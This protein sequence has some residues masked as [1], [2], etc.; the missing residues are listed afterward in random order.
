M[1]FFLKCEQVGLNSK[2]LI[3]MYSQYSCSFAEMK[4]VMYQVEKMSSTE[5]VVPLFQTY[6]F[7]LIKMDHLYK[8]QP[9]IYKTILSSSF[10]YFCTLFEHSLPIFTTFLQFGEFTK[11][12]IILLYFLHIF[13]EEKA[14]YKVG[15]AYSQNKEI[16][17]FPILL[18]KLFDFSIKNKEENY[19]INF[20]TQYLFHVTKYLINNED[21]LINVV[22][23]LVDSL[24]HEKHP[25]SLHT[26]FYFPYGI[27][28]YFETDPTNEIEIEEIVNKHFIDNNN[29]N[30]LGDYDNQ[31]VD[32]DLLCD[33]INMENNY[34][35]KLFYKDTRSLSFASF[36]LYSILRYQDRF[37]IGI[38]KK[39]KNIRKLM[40]IGYLSFLL[41]SPGSF[42]KLCINNNIKILKQVIEEFHCPYDYLDTN[43]ILSIPPIIA[44]CRHGNFNAVKYLIEKYQMDGKMEKVFYF[45]RKEM[46]I[47]CSKFDHLKLLKYLI[48]E[49]KFDY[50]VRLEDELMTKKLKLE[51][52]GKE[53]TFSFSG[54]LDYY[55]QSTLLSIAVINGRK[56]IIDYLLSLNYYQRLF[57]TIE[58]RLIK[59]KSECKLDSPVICAMGNQHYD[60]ALQLMNEKITIYQEKTQNPFIHH[61][62]RIN[63]QILFEKFLSL[64][65]KIDEE[66]LLEISFL[67]IFAKLEIFQFILNRFQFSSDFLLE[68]FPQKMFSLDD[69]LSL[70]FKKVCF[71]FEK[72]PIVVDQFNSK[73][74]SNWRS[75]FNWVIK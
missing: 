46:L 65:K 63:D 59:I 12:K 75:S 41:K 51:G 56:K 19:V 5:V 40:K 29:N 32:I 62:V 57:S 55:Y 73:F 8:K 27:E 17:T 64:F 38:F 67:S 70:Q 37:H 71:Y 14:F 13:L 22:V 15:K 10:S 35:E 33:E 18:N 47:E 42:C 20:Y 54:N 26:T 7:L 69:F 44:A 4:K 31:D 24:N 21:L 34:G 3:E 72:F 43:S 48:E 36:Y 9:K 45:Y 74:V 50:T 16:I 53:H 39:K 61:L 52:E 66:Y 49:Q 11:I 25:D 23:Y 68:R 60:I 58:F 6:L 2:E 30:E 1:E 28:T